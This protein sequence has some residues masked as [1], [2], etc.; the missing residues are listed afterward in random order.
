MIPKRM[1]FYWGG[2]A[3]SWMRYMTLYS[4]RKMNPDW[5]MVLCVSSDDIDSWVLSEKQDFLNYSGADYFDRISKLNVIV[6]N[7][8]F[9]D[10]FKDKFKV[11]SPIHE[12]D[13]YRY[14]KLY[15]D[16]GFYSDMDVLYFRPMDLV[17]NEII[18]QGSNTILYQCSGYVAI[19]FLGATKGNLFYKDLMLSASNMHNYNAYQSYGVELIYKFF[20]ISGNNLL[21]DNKIENKYDELKVY[22]ISKSLI[23]HYD[24]T[25]IEHTYRAPLGINSF[26]L[27]S[28]G[29]H[30]YAGNPISQKFNNL[31][32]ENNYTNY[33]IAFSEITKGVLY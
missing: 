2:S 5:E 26:D 23:Y 31:L 16:G 32:N 17:Y 20:G 24:W 15:N 8:Q 27:N 30:W 25:T 1:Y 22:V 33:E 4:F 3:M 11:I 10:D 13:L 29:Y 9:P 28:I 19:G 6:E 12:S 18:S 21:I 14:Y 7:V